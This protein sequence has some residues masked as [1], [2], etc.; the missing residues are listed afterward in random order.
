MVPGRRTAP[1]RGRL[2]LRLHRH[3]VSGAAHGAVRAHPRGVDVGWTL[4][5]LLQR[6][7]RCRQVELEML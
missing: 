6:W 5:T 7:G 3:G 1:H 2:A 4:G